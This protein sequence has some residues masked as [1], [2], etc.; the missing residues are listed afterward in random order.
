VPAAAQDATGDATAAAEDL[1]G[2]IATAGIEAAINSTL[3]LRFS[4]ENRYNSRPLFDTKKN[5][6]IT[7][8]AV[9]IR[10]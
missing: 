9:A 2:T 5:D 1:L 6:L 7:V 10:L 4:I 8:A 3:S